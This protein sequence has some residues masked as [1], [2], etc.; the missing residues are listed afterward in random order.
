MVLSFLFYAFLVY[1]AYR[2][3]FGL[4]IPLYRTTRKV[5]RSFR[6]MQEKMQQ[7]QAQYHDAY[8]TQDTRSTANAKGAEPGDYIEF[9]EVK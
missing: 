3:L 2:I 9:E 6:E 5:K 4:V 1:L 8:S 7:Q